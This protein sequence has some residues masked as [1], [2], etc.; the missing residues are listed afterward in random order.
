[1]KINDNLYKNYKALKVPYLP[2]YGE[3]HEMIEFCIFDRSEERTS[4]L[5]SRIP[6]AKNAK[7][8]HGES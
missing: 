2:I 7:I 6:N 1:M 8:D 5:S 4:I 3:F